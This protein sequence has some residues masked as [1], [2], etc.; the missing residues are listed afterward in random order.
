MMRDDLSVE[1][2]RSGISEH[3]LEEGRPIQIRQLRQIRHLGALLGNLDRDH[4]AIPPVREKALRMFPKV[5]RHRTGFDILPDVAHETP[6]P[7]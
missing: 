5:V 2:E 1:R 6:C 4:A 7:V 3:R